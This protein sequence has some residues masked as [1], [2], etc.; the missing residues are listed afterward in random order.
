MTTKTLSVNG[1]SNEPHTFTLLDHSGRCV[2][3]RA[4]YLYFTLSLRDSMTRTQQK[5]LRGIYGYKFG[6]F[7]AE[8]PQHD[9]TLHGNHPCLLLFGSALSNAGLQL[10]EMGL[11][12]TATINGYHYAFPVDADLTDFA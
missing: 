1:K 11:A 4:G 5:V 8:P 6:S 9:N 10:E 3:D 12:Q 2:G 7:P